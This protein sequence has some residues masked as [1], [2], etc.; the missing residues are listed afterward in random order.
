MCLVFARLEGRD[1]GFRDEGTHYLEMEAISML[2][3]Y[4]GSCGITEKLIIKSGSPAED[5]PKGR[6]G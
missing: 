5:L 6:D 1:R 3:I 2:W 4:L